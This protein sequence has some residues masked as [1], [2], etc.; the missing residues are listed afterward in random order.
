[1]G[2]ASADERPI[3]LPRSFLDMPRWWSGGADWLAA[4]PRAVR[5]RCDRWGLRIDGELTHGSN[6]IAVPVTRAGEPLILRLS[7]PGPD[8]RDHVRALR[9]WDGRGMVRLVN[10]D[11]DQGVLLLERLDAD[12]TLRS[13]PVDEAMIVLGRMMR[14]LAVPAPPDV[15]TT[16]TIVRTRSAEFDADWH[17]LGGPFPREILAEAIAAAARVSPP[18]ADLAV[19]GDC[20]RSRCSGHRANRG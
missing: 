6:A 2:D 10:A 17:R 20:T 1:M 14:R 13:V 12:G 15:P 19:N 5:D 9:F 18:G 3:T 8:I 16:A 11:I 4:L 7:P